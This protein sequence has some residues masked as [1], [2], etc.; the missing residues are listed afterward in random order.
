[1]K[2]FTTQQKQAAFSQKSC[3][4]IIQEIA[5][6]ILQPTIYLLKAKNQYLLFYFNRRV[7]QK[8]LKLFEKTY[9]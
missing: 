7:G 5:T 4:N 8:E 3:K 9:L 1:M 2:M 6:F